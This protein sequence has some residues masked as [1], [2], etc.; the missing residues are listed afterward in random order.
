MKSHVPETARSS[1]I[2]VAKAG[3]SPHRLGK[4]T[5]CHAGVFPSESDCS[6]ILPSI[7]AHKS[8]GALSLAPSASKWTL[9]LCSISWSGMSLV[10]IAVTPLPGLFPHLVS[11]VPKRTVKPG[12]DG[13]LP[14]SQDLR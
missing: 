6:S 3:S 2:V 11:Q 5:F 14:E 12:L 10:V 13:T 4:K 1:T 9:S 7:L 8:S